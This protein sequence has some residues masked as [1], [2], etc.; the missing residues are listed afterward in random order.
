MCLRRL[1]VWLQKLLKSGFITCFI[2]VWLQDPW[3]QSCKPQA[4]LAG[5]ALSILRGYG[6][7]R[8]SINTTNSSLLLVSLRARARY[9]QLSPQHVKHVRTPASFSPFPLDTYRWASPRRS[10]G[11]IGTW[12][13][14]SDPIRAR[15]GPNPSA[16]DD[17][18]SRVRPPRPQTAGCG[19]EEE[20]G[21]D[22]KD[23]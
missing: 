9:R 20:K 18:K 23:A 17:S 16:P 2:Q 11:S 14:A 13:R 19:W 15:L 21:R 8:E 6:S 3:N 7:P 22:N 10:A 5:S 12:G 4:M 1:E